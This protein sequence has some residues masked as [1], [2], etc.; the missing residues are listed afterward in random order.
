VRNR[1]PL[2]LLAL[3]GLNLIGWFST[4]VADTDF[5][6]H[7]RTGQLIVQSHSLPVPDAFSYTLAKA[8]EAYS[9]ESSLWH[10]NLTHEWLSQALLWLVYSL[11]GFPLVIVVR[12]L[13][14]AAAAGLAGLL[15]WR[16]SASLAWGVAG[17]LLG[18]GSL[19]LF[20]A[21]RPSIVS[22]L[23]AAVCI[24]IFEFGLP[25]WLL[26][27]L[28]VV[29]ANLHGGFF[30]GW[31]ICGIYGVSAWRA[32]ERRVAAWC[33]AFIVASGL[34]PNFYGVATTL[35]H[36]RSSPMT[37]TL[38]EWQSLGLFGPPYLFQALF[39]ATLVLFFIA[40]RRVKLSDWALAAA[41]GAAGWMAFRNVPLFGLAAPMML[42]SYAPKWRR[43]AWLGPLVALVLVGGLGWGAWTGKACRWNVESARMPVESAEFLLKNNIP[44]PIL[45]T[46]GD[47]GYLI[48]RLWPRY[49]VFIDGRS[50]SER[51][52]SDYRILLGALGPGAEAERARKLDHWGIQT[53]VL[54]AFQPDGTIY[55]LTVGLTDQKQKT[56]HLIHADAHAM[57]F[58]RSVPAGL[59]EVP[60]EQI[61]AHLEAACSAMLDG[62]DAAPECAR[63]M[64]YYFAERDDPARSR[65]WLVEY[66]SRVPVVD[67][68]VQRALT[69]R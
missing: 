24:A 68:A 50:L 63:G 25:L 11:G 47:G 29:W 44:G 35:M 3:V 61:D 62:P 56:W 18:G 52:F 20:T 17:A 1:L 65:R 34:N 2:L 64:G 38:V 4:P 54:E 32:G 28:A 26:P 15:A 49:Q 5:W 46:Y 14:L 7:L 42:A 10:F 19:I 60:P 9:G 59:Q 53:I 69:A 21:D 8:H 67:P 45:N 13:I 6:W 66:S 41:F 58:C 30:L 40:G 12:A 51:V 43:P 39:V 57:V 55:P 16:R 36:Y 22:F 48:W 27:V 37:A 23:L 31:V 33:A